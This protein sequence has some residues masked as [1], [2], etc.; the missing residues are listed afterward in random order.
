[1]KMKE[2]GGPYTLNLPFVLPI[3]NSK[4]S[5]KLDWSSLLKELTVNA[6]LYI[7]LTVVNYRNKKPLLIFAYQ[8]SFIFVSV[9][10][11]AIT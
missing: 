10:K 5:I 4:A 8:E 2:G 1:M 11:L 7:Y 9:K 6:D 3:K